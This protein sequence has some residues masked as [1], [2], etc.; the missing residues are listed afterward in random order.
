M[1]FDVRVIVDSVRKSVS[2]NNLSQYEHPQD[3]SNNNMEDVLAAD[4]ASAD[5]V[6]VHNSGKHR[7]RKRGLI[8]YLHGL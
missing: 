2:L 4:Y 5:D 6:V 8:N 7:K 1:L 3:G